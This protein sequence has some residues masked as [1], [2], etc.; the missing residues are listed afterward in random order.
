MNSS[1]DIVPI[2]PIP[3]PLSSVPLSFW[4][5][6]N[7]ASALPIFYIA[8]YPSNESFDTDTNNGFCSCCGYAP[9]NLIKELTKL[10]PE[11]LIKKI[12]E[13]LGDKVQFK[14]GIISLTIRYINTYSDE[15]GITYKDPHEKEGNELQNYLLNHLKT[16]QEKYYSEDSKDFISIYEFILG[17]KVPDIGYPYILLQWLENNKLIEHGVAIRCAWI[18]T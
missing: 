3:R 17:L 6:T 11:E 14:E 4:F 1:V 10:N 18:K 9:S 16:E 2:E 8:G 5:N 7:P 15:K 12:T 13:D